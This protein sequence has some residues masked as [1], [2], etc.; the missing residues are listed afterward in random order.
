MEIQKSKD[1]QLIINEIFK[2]KDNEFSAYLA[3]VKESEA[4]KAIGIAINEKEFADLNQSDKR[5]Y[6]INLETIRLLM[7]KMNPNL[8]FKD[9]FNEFMQHKKPSQSSFAYFMGTN[10][11]IS[12]LTPD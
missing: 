1:C 3:R 6:L 4:I 12:D 8:L 10:S 9:K 11:T 2:L 7:R 5:S